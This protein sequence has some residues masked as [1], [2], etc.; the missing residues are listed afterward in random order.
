MIIVLTSIT[1]I[2][3]HSLSIACFVS[4]VED[5]LIEKLLLWWDEDY[6][7]EQ[8]VI[9]DAINRILNMKLRGP[10][11]KIMYIDTRYKVFH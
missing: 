6:H 10:E 11:T 3:F 1:L 5:V 9:N 7:Q 2:P 4:Q 8:V